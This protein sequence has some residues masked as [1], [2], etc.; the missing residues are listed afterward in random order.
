MIEVK[1]LKTIQALERYGT[2]NQAAEALF[3]TQSALSHQLKQLESLL[4]QRLFERKTQPIQWTP[5]GKVLLELAE[6]VLPQVAQAEQN[7]QRLQSGQ[8]GR[9]WLGVECHTCF[10]W[11]LP[12]LRHYQKQLPDVEV[13]IIAQL[14]RPPLE[15]LK[16]HEIDLVITSEQVVDGTV[17][18]IPLFEYEVQLTVSPQHRLA[19]QTVCH[20]QDLMQETLLTYP[21]AYDKLDIFKS[22]LWPAKIQPKAIRH[23]EMSVMLLQWVEA[24][25]GVAAFPK[26]LLDSQPEFNHLK[27]LQLGEKGITAKLY[28]AVR[29]SEVQQ[30]YL[31]TFIEQVQEQ[32]R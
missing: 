30:P 21:V 26:W 22:F 17:D 20:P 9:L 28:A 11:L 31:Q 1:H 23:S 16:K 32:M 12:V 27:R 19:K 4:E 25:Q 14:H 10:E 18:F 29:K 8:K 7:L 5:A 24:N 6:S 3:M 2:V 15:A 13:D